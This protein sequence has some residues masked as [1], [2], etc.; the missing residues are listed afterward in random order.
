MAR[1]GSLLWLAGHS[2]VPHSGPTVPPHWT[3][4]C[5]KVGLSGTFLRRESRSAGGYQ[6]LP[7]L[8]VAHSA[9]KTPEESP[10]LPL[11][12]FLLC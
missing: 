3:P 8:C 5:C 11:G 4:Q 10:L 12:L 1:V 2:T 9:L 7:P 6:Q